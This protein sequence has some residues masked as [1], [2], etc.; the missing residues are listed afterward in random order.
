MQQLPVLPKL[1]EGAPQQLSFIQPRNTHT[2]WVL[3]LWPLHYRVANLDYP[4][5]P[6]WIGMITQ[7]QLRTVKGGLTLA[8]TSVDFATPV[9]ALAYTLPVQHVLARRQPGDASVLLIW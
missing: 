1:N 5:Q 7:E 6:L 3:R 8:Q 9:Q 2:R 4:A